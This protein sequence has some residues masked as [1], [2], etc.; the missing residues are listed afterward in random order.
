MHKI[1]SYLLLCI[2]LFIIAFA[3][4]GMYQV[5]TGSNGVTELVHITESSMSVQMLPLRLP[6]EQM[7]T[8]VNLGLFSLFMF[9]LLLAGGKIAIIGCNLLKNERI[10]DALICLNKNEVPSVDKFKQL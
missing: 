1:L 9:F 3:I 2:G 10:Y 8:L 5:F 7:S 6:M 4:H